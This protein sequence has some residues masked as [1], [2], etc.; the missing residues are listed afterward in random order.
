MGSQVSTLSIWIPILIDDFE[1]FKASM[2]EVTKDMVEI[3]RGLV[4]E[5]ESEGVTE[6][7]SSHDKTGM[8]EEFLLMGEQGQ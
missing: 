1:M 4:L 5:V 3:A 7:L 6:F 8:D 2:E